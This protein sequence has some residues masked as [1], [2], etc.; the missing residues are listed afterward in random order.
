[1]DSHH[2]CS[3][4]IHGDGGGSGGGGGDDGGASHRDAALYSQSLFFFVYNGKQ[5]ASLQPLFGP[6][7]PFLVVFT[8]CGLCRAVGTGEGRMLPHC[9]R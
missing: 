8:F 9:D 3:R 4:L 6:A 5:K 1:M 7:V 2:T